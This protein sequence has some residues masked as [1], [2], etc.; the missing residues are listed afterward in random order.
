[1]CATVAVS[2][3]LSRFVHSPIDGDRDGKWS[4][5]VYT[6]TVYVLRPFV[7]INNLSIR[8]SEFSFVPFNVSHSA[9][10]KKQKLCQVIFIYLMF[11]ERSRAR[12]EESGARERERE[13]KMKSP[14]LGHSAY[15]VGSVWCSGTL[16]KLWRCC[17]P[18]CTISDGERP[19]SSLLL[20]III[21]I[22]FGF[23]RFPSFSLSHS[24]TAHT[25][26]LYS[27]VNNSMRWFF[28]VNPQ[29]K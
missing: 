25:Y 8:C 12:S 9:L 11:H 27:L 1:M 15:R 19:K 4:A 18:T 23:G 16:C 2:L 5:V 28:A 6:T 22:I 14:N 29:W 20:I 26:T 3:A 13:N 7:S 10:P 24:T 17:N 21:I